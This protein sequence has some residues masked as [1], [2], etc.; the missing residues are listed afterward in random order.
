MDGKNEETRI[1]VSGSP[2]SKEMPPPAKR[3]RKKRG[4][5]P[6]A[7]FDIDTL[8]G[9]S[10]LTVLEAAAIIRRTPS[11]LEQWRR[12]PNHPLKWR[13]VDGRPLYRVDAVRDYLASRDKATKPSQPHS[14]RGDGRATRP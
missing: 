7:T 6:P 3:G 1:G 2:G 8:P 11:A 4:V 9:S 5:P 12:D 10:N 13:Y 14:A